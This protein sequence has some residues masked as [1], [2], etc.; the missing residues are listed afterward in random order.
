LSGA[1]WILLC[2]WDLKRD[3]RISTRWGKILGV[4]GL[5]MIGGGPGSMMGVMWWWREEILADRKTLE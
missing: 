3:K 5:V 2:F 1:V 4:M